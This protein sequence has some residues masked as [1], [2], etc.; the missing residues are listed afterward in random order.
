[1]WNMTNCTAASALCVCVCVCVSLRISTKV[2][3]QK[4]SWRSHTLR[5]SVCV[6]VCVWQQIKSH[7]H[8]CA[9]SAKQYFF[10]FCLHRCL[11]SLLCLKAAHVV[12]RMMLFELSGPPYS[13]MFCFVPQLSESL[14]TLTVTGV[15]GAIKSRPPSSC[16]CWLSCQA[17]S[18]E[19]LA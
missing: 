3:T 15:T 18:M 9:D 4:T 14:L 19:R 11:S 12:R 17:F 13:H 1:M 16:V 5:L 6:C 2:W 8:T 10:F 7:T